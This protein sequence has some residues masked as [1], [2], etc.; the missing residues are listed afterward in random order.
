MITFDYKA[1]PVD[2]YETLAMSTI[3]A[4]YGVPMKH[5]ELAQNYMAIKKESF[6]LSLFLCSDQD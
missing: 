6:M 5:R 2:E 1:T 4:G 3:L